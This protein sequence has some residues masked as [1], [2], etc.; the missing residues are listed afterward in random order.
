MMASSLPN[1]GR[2]YTWAG[3]RCL[4]REFHIIHSYT[5]IRA[6]V[7]TLVLY[8]RNIYCDIFIAAI[9]EYFY[10]FCR[11]RYRTFRYHS[12]VDGR[13]LHI[14]DNKW[15]FLAMLR[16]IRPC[17]CWF[18]PAMRFTSCYPRLS[19]LLQSISRRAQ[20]IYHYNAYHDRALA[21]SYTSWAPASAALIRLLR[22]RQLHFRLA[23][24]SVR[25]ASLRE[26]L[27]RSAP[28]AAIGF[29]RWLR[30]C[31]LS[32]RHLALACCSISRC[33][34]SCYSYHA[35]ILSLKRCRAAA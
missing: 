6:F 12:G 30:L 18:F 10:Y 35:P 5:P 4:A 7:Y 24:T 13:R 27:A 25:C 29:Y 15:Y 1:D 20:R 31:A 8:Y 17:N 19:T 34:A 26:R 32:P 9:Y 16:Q 28:S 22:R 11:A 3:K 14:I 21:T 2:V 33:F 23:A